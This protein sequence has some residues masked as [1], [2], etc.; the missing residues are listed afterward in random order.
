MLKLKI[1][2]II[3]SITLCSF[4]FTTILF[5]LNEIFAAGP[6]I[7][8]G[9]DLS[10]YTKS[11]TTGEDNTG[12][13]QDLNSSWFKDSGGNRT[14]P[15]SLN[16]TSISEV[17]PAVI[18]CTG[19][20]NKV[21]KSLN[22]FL[23]PS[24]KSAPDKTYGDETPITPKDLEIELK[25][26]NQYG[27][28]G[29]WGDSPDEDS[30]FPATPEINAVPIDSK[31]I[32]ANTKE[33]ADKAAA[34]EQ[35]E[36]EAK[37]RQECIDG[38]AYSLAKAQLAK[39]TQTT[40]NWI[41][42]GFN[43]DPLYIRDRESY[44]QSIA[45]G[46]LLNLVG[47]L[48]SIE[49]RYI[50]P[51]GRS[52]ARSIINSQKSTYESRAQSTLDRSL[53][54]GATTEDFAN[55]FSKGGWDGWFSLTQNDQNNPLGFGIMTSQE[56]ADRTAE[57]TNTAIAELAE[58]KGF[59]SQKRC[60]EYEKDSTYKASDAGEVSG[61]AGNRTVDRDKT[62]RCI[63]Y[64]VVT[65]GSIIAE[66]TATALTSNI[67]QLELADS[68]NESLNAVFSALVN[69][70]ID[71]GLSSLS[72]FSS[73]ALN[74]AK[75]DSGTNNEGEGSNRIYDSSGNDITGQLG[76]TDAN[77]NVLSVNKGR[78]WYST[79]T[80][81][82]ITKDLG[83]IVKVRR[84][85]GKAEK[86]IYKK[87][88]ITLQKD[89]TEAVKLSMVTLPKITPALGELDYC[90]PGPNPSWEGP[91]KDQIN[92][93]IEYLN[94]L[95]WNPVTGTVESPEDKDDSKFKQVAKLGVKVFLFTNPGIYLLANMFNVEGQVKS[96]WQSTVN[97]FGGKTKAQKEAEAAAKSEEERIQALKDAE[98]AFY[99]GRTKSI[100][101]IKDDFFEYKKHIDELYGEGSVM[102]NADPNNPF[103][104]PMAEAG[105]QA[106]KYITTYDTNSKQ[107]IR[108]YK[109]LINQSNAN[110]YKLNVI[111]K[112]VDAIVAAA[113]K[114]RAA[115]IN[116]NGIPMIDPS[117]YDMNGV[118][119]AGL[120][121]IVGGTMGN[122]GGGGGVTQG[123]DPVGGKT[124]SDTSSSKPVG[125]T[126][127][128][129]TVS[130][131]TDVIPNFDLTI[132]ENKLSCEATIT[133]TN[134]STGTTTDIAWGV[135][136]GSNPAVYSKKTFNYVNTFS[137]K[138]QSGVANITL[139]V[140][141]K[142]GVA[143]SLSKTVS[144]PKRS[145]NSIGLP[146]LQ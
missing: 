63:R 20:V 140:K 52:V 40:V 110:I 60:A 54:D 62:R 103:Y 10:E 33:A 107:A 75:R 106:T 18:G 94:N 126:P 76:T 12:G 26:G 92:N 132:K 22:S 3:A 4:V 1:Q 125:A 105:L 145:F 35:K 29:G 78:G 51:F 137:T 69:Q 83:D 122:T 112:E 38:I 123:P 144:I 27:Q 102:R 17:L 104:L 68:L 98:A 109:D 43:G 55:D 2:K 32:A 117:C 113:R 136:I 11:T 67:R 119:Q 118:E 21:E 127:A 146:C 85:N 37:L 121:P 129:G 49:N 124:T 95:Y 8:E 81:F 66:Q 30:T 89:Y 42:S 13:G 116:K 84:V 9:T 90:I 61:Y 97:L 87:G 71:Q 79:G 101:K 31:I 128:D 46:Q 77:G 65:P 82:D 14:N 70:M 39:M 19:I 73:E 134:K 45:D 93:V 74:K 135:K 80:T 142:N 25:K 143:S 6:Y 24:E 16:I 57:K 72:S 7:P 91:V 138:N 114:R 88:V 44:F 99:D 111:K 64:E 59:L 53:R 56:L 50:Y 141:N 86:Y 36:K 41:N 131:G 139:T 48:A 58:G 133:A 115:E 100:Q 23:N 108:D 130:A 47:P 28:G 96:I 120:A 15:Y 34:I 5:P